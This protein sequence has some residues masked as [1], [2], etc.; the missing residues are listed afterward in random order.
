VLR[1]WVEK[2]DAL[3][4]KRNHFLKAFRGQHGFDRTRYTSEQSAEFE[5]GLARVNDEEDRLR[6]A[7]AL[8]LGAQP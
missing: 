6:R 3:D 2:Q 5:A 7:A 4:R 8:E 1:G